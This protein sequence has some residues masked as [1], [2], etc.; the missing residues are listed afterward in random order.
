VSGGCSVVTAGED[1]AD[2][3]E[4]RV[5]LAGGWVSERFGRCLIAGPARVVQRVASELR[6]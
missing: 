6:V 2:E 4:A 5:V 3:L 1:L